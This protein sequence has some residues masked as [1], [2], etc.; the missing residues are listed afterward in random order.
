MR[1]V[2]H[3]EIL[4]GPKL[5][6]PP[7]LSLR[8]P[9]LLSHKSLS[10]HVFKPLLLEP[11]PIFLPSFGPQKKIPTPPLQLFSPLAL[12]FSRS[13]YSQPS[14]TLC[15]PVQ[16]GRPPISLIPGVVRRIIMIEN[17][18]KLLPGRGLHICLID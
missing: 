2:K 18:P 17:H 9:F 8:R 6:T 5:Q 10:C 12:S 7:Q 3:A 16:S 4:P 15:I 14:P 11:S 1:Y 13:F